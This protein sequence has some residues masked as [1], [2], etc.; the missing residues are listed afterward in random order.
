MKPIYKPVSTG[1]EKLGQGGFGE[2]FGGI[3]TVDGESYEVAIKKVKI[4]GLEGNTAEI[5]YANYK[6]QSRYREEGMFSSEM[7]KVASNRST[8][9]LPC[10]A[11]IRS[12]L[13]FNFIIN[14]I[15]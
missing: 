14:F 5:A 1:S 4:E 11:Y 6:Q 15:N 12:V 7:S 3:Y 8:N 13:I 2:V 9:I 10:L